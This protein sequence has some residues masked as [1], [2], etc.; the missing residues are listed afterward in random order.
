[1]PCQK[2]NLKKRG[3]LKK[4]M[5]ADI[6]IF[7]PASIEDLSSPLFPNRYPKGIEYVLVRGE[8][9][10]KNGKYNGKTAGKIIKNN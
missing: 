5:I 2:F 8:I 10:V 3:I 1:M 6:V 9:V 7:N 4:G